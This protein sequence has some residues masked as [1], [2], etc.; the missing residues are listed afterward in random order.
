ML[1]SVHTLPT[2]PRPLNLRR[3]CSEEGRTVLMVEQ[4]VIAGTAVADYIYVLVL[5]ADKIEGAKAEFDA[6]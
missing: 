1:A 3:L 2:K 5:G 4:N 6:K